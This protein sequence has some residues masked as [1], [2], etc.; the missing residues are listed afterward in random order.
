[1]TRW[2]PRLLL[3]AVAVLAPALA[4]CEAGLN[5]PTLQYHPAN[6]AANRIVNGISFANVFVLGPVPG[7][8]LP[9]GGRASVFLALESAVGHDRLISVSAPG[10]ATAVQLAGAPVDLPGQTL[11][12]MSGPAPQV[13]LTGLTSPL[14]PGQTVSLSFTFATAGTITLNVPVEP[15]A[16]DWA[17]FSPPPASP[18][19]TPKPGVSKSAP[20]SPGASG[21]AS[22]SVGGASSTATPG[23]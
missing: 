2:N 21:T 12:D 1:M 17:T 8:A 9:V 6:F 20:P 16:Y 19:A 13:V 14:L 5:A 18:T 3:A 23:P 7:A 15:R 4:G 11:V 22:A 10:T